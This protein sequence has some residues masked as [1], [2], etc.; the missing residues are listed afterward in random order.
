MRVVIADDAVLVRDGIARLL[1][2]H[3][4]EI[5]GLAGDAVGLRRLVRTARPDASIVDIRMPPSHTDEGIRAAQEIRATMP[6][7]SV[8][9][10]SQDLNPA[11]AMRL[12]EQ[13]PAHVG[14]FLK[15]HVGRIEDLVDALHRV[16]AGECVVDRAVVREMMDRRR[17]PDPLARLSAREREI[18]QLMAEGRSNQGICKA[19]FVSPKTVETHIRSLFG[20]LELAEV[21]HDNRRVLAVL[22]YLRG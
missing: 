22:R 8:V 10:L 20:K 12:L 15:E 16:V 11:Y 1:T 2:D 7:T 5:V 17:R 21:P 13:S 14:Y 18:L 9:V 3:G 6:E 19:L 4:I